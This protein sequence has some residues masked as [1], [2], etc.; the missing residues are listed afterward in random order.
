MLSYENIKL[1][2]KGKNYF[3]RE[4]LLQTKDWQLNDASKEISSFVCNRATTDFGGS[5]YEVW[6]TLDIPTNIGPWKLH[7]LPGVIVNVEDTNK[8]VSFRL[9]KVEY[10]KFIPK[11]KKNYISF[12]H[13]NHKL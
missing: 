11:S 8:E 13:R 6:Y 2:R 7:G 9:V 4:K 1:R 12:K 3:I 5:S 10:N